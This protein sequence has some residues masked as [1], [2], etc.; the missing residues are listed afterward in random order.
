MN[1]LLILNCIYNGCH[2]WKSIKQ[3]TRYN[4]FILT[5]NLKFLVSKG[6]VKKENKKY[7]IT[8]EGNSYLKDLSKSL[9]NRLDKK[10]KKAYNIM[11]KVN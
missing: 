4:P 2:N 6:Y 8:K 7:S 9:V 1:S 3:E 11:K 5:K 10:Y